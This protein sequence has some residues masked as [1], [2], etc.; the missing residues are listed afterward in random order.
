[1][2]NFKVFDRRAHGL[3]ACFPPHVSPS[4]Y[5]SFHHP[6]SQLPSLFRHVPFLSNIFPSSPNSRF[7]PTPISLSLYRSVSRGREESRYNTPL[8]FL[9]PLLHRF[10]IALLPSHTVLSQ[11]SLL[12]LDSEIGSFVY[13]IADTLRLWASLLCFHSV[14]CVF[15]LWVV[16]VL[17]LSWFGHPWDLL[18][19]LQFEPRWRCV[20]DLELPRTKMLLCLTSQVRNV[21]WNLFW[22]LPHLIR[23]MCWG[24]SLWLC[25]NGLCGLGWFVCFQ[26]VW[27]CALV[28]FVQPLIGMEE[29]TFGWCGPHSQR[30]RVNCK[31]G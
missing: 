24:V 27:L 26:R 3:T 23:V 14:L 10:P 6:P 19:R 28:A 18:R 16:W 21:P 22:K 7:F 12:T 15:G 20:W 8:A 11:S 2:C 5:F 30:G 4:P 29:V 31:I 13:S 17:G 9:A 1:M 25:G